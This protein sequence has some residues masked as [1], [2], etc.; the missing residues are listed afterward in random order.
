VLDAGGAQHVLGLGQ[1][2]AGGSDGVGVAGATN[3][4]AGAVAG[5]VVAVLGGC[6]ACRGAD[7]AVQVE[8]QPPLSLTS[9]RFMR[10]IR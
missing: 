1:F 2:V 7:H 5:G 10:A 8:N 4:F 9:C 6:V 3:G